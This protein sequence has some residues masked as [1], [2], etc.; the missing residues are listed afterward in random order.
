MVGKKFMT[1]ILTY[2]FVFFSSS[3][4]AIDNPDAVDYT[5]RYLEVVS[6][7]E[8]QLNTIDSTGVDVLAK[9]SNYMDFLDSELNNAYGL[10]RE[11]IPSK[12]FDNLKQSQ[13]QWIKYRDAEFEFIDVNWVQ[14]N[15]G[16][17]SRLSR[18]HYKASVIK[19]RTTQLYD[20]VKNY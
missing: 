2:C 13:R 4:F 17:S 1:Y 6:Q 20:Y 19:S 16:T 7:Y 8:S 18:F 12:E 15:F 10:A 9:Y 11:K 5:Q 14:E 3:S